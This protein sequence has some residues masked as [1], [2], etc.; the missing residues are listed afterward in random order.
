MIIEIKCFATLARFAPEDAAAHPIREGETVA[1]VMARLGVD[2]A[3]VKLIFI[4]GIKVETD[5]VLTNG[6]RLGLFPAVGGG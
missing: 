6:D 3:D 4:N 1:E 5:A 2:P